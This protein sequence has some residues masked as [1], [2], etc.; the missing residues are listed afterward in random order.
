MGVA[1]L[2]GAAAWGGSL[3]T[4]A[5]PVVPA[6]PPDAPRTFQGTGTLKTEAFHLRGGSYRVQWEAAVPASD[7]ECPY[8]VALAN[9]ATG[10]QRDVLVMVR[11]KA[12][13][14]RGSSAA[15]GIPAGDYY[16]NVASSCAWSVTLAPP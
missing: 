10:A 15:H 8:A 11:P 3:Q 6:G 7:S 2:L 5:R 1:V 4:Q 13:A 9:A 16:L 12:P 14:Q